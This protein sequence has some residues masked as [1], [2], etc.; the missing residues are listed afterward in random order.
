MEKTTWPYDWLN[1]DDYKARGAVKGKMVLS[2]GRPAS[3]A[4]VFLGDNDSSLS[5]LRQGRGYSYTVYADD[6]GIFEIDNVRA[7][8][9]KLVSWSNGSSIADVS[10]NATQSDVSVEDSIVTNI[11]TLTWEVSGRKQLFRVG[12]FDRTTQG[13]KFGG[14]PREYGLAM[15]CLADIV[16]DVTQDSVDEWCYAQTKVGNW[17]IQFPFEEDP[18]RDTA[19]VIL[20][21][22]GYGNGAHF[23]VL[24]NGERIGSVNAGDL[25]NDGAL[26]RSCTSAGQWNSLQYTFTSSFLKPGETNE[27]TLWLYENIWEE[28]EGITSPQRG[29]MYD[30]I[31][32][33][34]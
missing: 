26:Y 18:G 14:A 27:L 6:T 30:A 10:T 1:D 34:W 29:P 20:S 22:A 33:E 4:A 19:V 5:T 8:V 23:H 28:I 25:P 7:G 32:L 21:L 15:E 24:V 11:N 31:A 13:F 12:D 9:Y 17:T 2:D 3:N 16:F